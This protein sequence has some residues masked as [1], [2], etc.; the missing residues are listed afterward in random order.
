MHLIAF[1]SSATYKVVE[2]GLTTIAKRVENLLAI[3]GSAYR[4][5]PAAPERFRK[6]IPVYVLNQYRP[7][8]T[9]AILKLALDPF[10]I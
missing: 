9:G 1:M 8:T 3:T 7:A 10:R 5:C 2:E 6:T 4:C